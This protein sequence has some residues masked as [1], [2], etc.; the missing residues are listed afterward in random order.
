MVTN[1]LKNKRCGLGEQA[2]R[3][4]VQTSSPSFFLHNGGEFVKVAL[5][6][7]PVKG[8]GGAGIGIFTM[9]VCSHSACFGPAFTT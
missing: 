7:L 6:V 2:N 8:L 4:G 1:F 5:V 3:H 9:A